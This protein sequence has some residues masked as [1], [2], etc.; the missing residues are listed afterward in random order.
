MPMSSNRPSLIRTGCRFAFASATG[1]VHAASAEV[2][3]CLSSA[4]NHA[5]RWPAFAEAW[6]EAAG[7]GHES[8][9]AALIVE[10]RN[11][12]SGASGADDRES[13]PK[14]RIVEM[15]AE[16]ALACLNAYRKRIAVEGSAAE[17]QELDSARR[18]E[19]DERLRLKLAMLARSDDGRG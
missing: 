2:G 4:Y 17:A 15:T 5:E 3:L 11:L 9:E 6:R 10:G 12:F 1:N 8:L 7:D 16:H 14:V 18:A 19:M 13:A